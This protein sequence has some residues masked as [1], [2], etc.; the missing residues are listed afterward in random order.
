MNA[1][2]I[3]KTENFNKHHVSLPLQRPTPHCQIVPVLE[4]SWCGRVLHLPLPGAS[5]SDMPRFSL[6]P[7]KMWCGTHST[8]GNSR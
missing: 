7:L 6:L 2:Q 1:F 4:E 8:E 5:P 3:Q